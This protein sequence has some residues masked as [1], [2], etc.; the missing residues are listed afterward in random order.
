MFFILIK[1]KIFLQ[2]CMN[3]L[4]IQSIQNGITTTVSELDQLQ[5]QRD[6]LLDWINKQEQ[7]IIDWASKPIKLRPEASKQEI[8][9]MNDLLNAIGDKRAQLMTE[10]TGSCKFSYSVYLLFSKENDNIHNILKEIRQKNISDRFN[11]FKYIFSVV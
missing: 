8:S 3:L 5:K 2:Q 10:M 9:L 6:D 4:K 1:M 11:L 7:H